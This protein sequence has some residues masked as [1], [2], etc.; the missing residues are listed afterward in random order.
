MFKIRIKTSIS[1]T[2]LEKRAYSYWKPWWQWNK[3][4]KGKTLAVPSHKWWQRCDLLKTKVLRPNSPPV[5]NQSTIS[6]RPRKK[7][8]YHQQAALDLWSHWICVNR[9]WQFTLVL[10]VH[11]CNTPN[12]SHYSSIFI[13]LSV[14]TYLLRKAQPEQYLPRSNGDWEIRQS[15]VT[16]TDRSSHHSVRVV[17]LF[18]VELWILG[19]CLWVEARRK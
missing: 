7:R 11:Y 1:G 4:I 18:S 16:T 6:N 17:T 13:F 3:P 12:C 8:T 2:S 5:E 14:Q 19:L 15:W 9:N 10:F